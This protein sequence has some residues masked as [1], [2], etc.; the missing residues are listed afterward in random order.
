METLEPGRILFIG[1]EEGDKTSLC[2]IIAEKNYF[3][4]GVLGGENI[5]RELREQNI[6]LLLIDTEKPPLDLDVLL[7]EVRKKDPLIGIIL[8]TDSRI[9]PFPEYGEDVFYDYVVKPFATEELFMKM[10]RVM[11]LRFLQTSEQLYRSLFENT[12]EELRE[13]EKYY[14]LRNEHSEKNRDILIE[15][16]D[17]IHESYQD[18]ENLFMSFVMTI[19]N[20]VEGKGPWKKGH[21][22]KVA[23]YASKIAEEMGLGH[24]E[25][26]DL[27]LAALLHD[28]GNLAV[29]DELID[30]PAKLTEEEYESIRKHSVHG[31]EMLKRVKQLKNI[32]PIVRHHHEHY[33][34]CGYPDGLKGDR[35]PVGARI[36]NLADSFESMTAARPYRT[37]PGRECAL[38]E[39]ARCIGTQF[40][41]DIAKI[42][43]KVL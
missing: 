27:S 14:S 29:P 38:Q 7:R 4:T 31:A 41:P 15:I 18:L 9:K 17:E 19:T 13:A 1:H 3:V 28:I 42:A 21:S 24:D 43:L 23:F 35:I 6:D 39:V 40:D 12:A 32:I 11:R 2:E 5:F 16:I 33:D 8:I 25:R 26:R 10:S 20:S 22:E 37:T 30:R 34:G 36:I